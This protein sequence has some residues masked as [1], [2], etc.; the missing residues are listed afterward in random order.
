MREVKELNTRKG[1]SFEYEIVEAEKIEIPDMENIYENKE[2]F[3]KYYETLPEILYNKAEEL[4]EKEVRMEKDYYYKNL[5]KMKKCKFLEWKKN[6]HKIIKENRHQ[7][8]KVEVIL[9]AKPK[10]RPFE[11]TSKVYEWIGR[12]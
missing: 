11:S 3:Q 4:I 1:L 5:M 7:N 12:I 10:Q 2:Y 6:A 8:S 9:I